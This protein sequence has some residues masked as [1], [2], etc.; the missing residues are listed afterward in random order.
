MLAE[1]IDRQQANRIK[2]DRFRVDL[3]E[4]Y[5]CEAK[6]RPQEGNHNASVSIICVPFRATGRAP[7]V[8]RGAGKGSRPNS[9]RH[10]IRPPLGRQQAAADP[11]AA[12]E[13]HCKAQALKIANAGQAR[14]PSASQRLVDDEPED[15]DITD[16]DDQDHTPKKGK[17][18]PSRRR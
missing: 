12:Y 17:K 7:E 4:G 1:A 18:K 13:A 14:E 9:R 5:R 3:R 16:G 15:A 8:T 2:F 11:D 10:G 6:R